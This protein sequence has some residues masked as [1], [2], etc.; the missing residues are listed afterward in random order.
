[1]ASNHCIL[2][3]SLLS[4]TEPK[5]KKKCGRGSPQR[6]ATSALRQASPQPP[7]QLQ[8]Q[9]QPPPHVPCPSVPAPQPRPPAPHASTGRAAPPPRTTPAS[10]PPSHVL[11][12]PFITPPPALPGPRPYAPFAPPHVAPIQSTFGPATPHYALPLPSLPYSAVAQPPQSTVSHFPLPYLVAHVVYALA[13]LHPATDAASPDFHYL[14]LLVGFVGNGGVCELLTALLCVASDPSVV[15][16]ALE[17]AARVC[18]A[19]PP[20]GPDA[21]QRFGSDHSRHVVL[22]LLMK[23]PKTRDIS[24]ALLKL[25]AALASAHRVQLGEVACR[26]VLAIIRSYMTI[27]MVQLEAWRALDLLTDRTPQSQARL[28]SVP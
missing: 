19:P 4:L 22:H 20:W 24:I 10:A 17:A 11:P 1:M 8:P 27:P 26:S 16:H 21:V 5:P 3:P 12:P 15:A 7:P 28:P 6:G 18:Q 14:A 13:Q 25:T 9:A 23:V 2:S